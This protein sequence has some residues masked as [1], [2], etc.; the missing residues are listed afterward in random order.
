ME[1]PSFS[2]FQIAS[3]YIGTVVGAGFAS[4]QEVLQFFD[5]FGLFGLPGILVSTALFF[6]IGYSI[7]MLGRHLAAQSHVTIVRFTNG[8]VLGSF[9]DIIITLFLFGGLSAMIAGAGAVF[10][11]QFSVSPVWGTAVMALVTLLTV[12]TGTRGVIRAISYVVPFL[13]VPCCSSRYTA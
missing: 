5:A 8:P 9:I 12:V 1:K 6:F 7:L 4:G 3:A 13:I 2:I 10:R 11:E